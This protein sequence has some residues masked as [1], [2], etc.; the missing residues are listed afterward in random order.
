MGV[1][2][3][4]N[5]IATCERLGEVSLGG[6][7]LESAD[8]ALLDVTKFTIDQHV[9]MQPSAIAYFGFL[10]KVTARKL[11]NVE[12]DF[13]HWTKRKFAEARASVESGTSSKTSV[14]VE[15][16]KGR[17][18]TDNE[19]KIKEWEEKIDKAQEAYDALDAWFEAFK[20]KSFS[21]RET[22]SIE[23]DE[24]FT[25]TSISGKRNDDSEPNSVKMDKVREIMK[26]RREQGQ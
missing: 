17:H 26:R 22:V 21:I 3:I 20:Q 19:A 5:I 24:R 16:I 14:K 2:V 4:K 10:K 15:D 9:A 7:K 1:D 6:I 8:P 25:S 23:E 13:D 18:A 12:S 11:A